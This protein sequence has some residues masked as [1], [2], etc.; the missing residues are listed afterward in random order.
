MEVE[1]ADDELDR[2]EVDPKATAGHG[3]AVDR[4]FRKAIQ[5]LRAAHDERDLYANR[6][7]H[8]EKLKGDRSHQR[9]VRCNKQWRLI[10]EIHEGGRGHLIRVIAIED[11][12]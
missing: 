12:H 10:L 1:F 7:L 2:L 8:F 5:A 3:A 9:S 6:G 11:Y 4:G